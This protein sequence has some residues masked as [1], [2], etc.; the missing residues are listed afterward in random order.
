M[1]DTQNFASRY[2]YV[3]HDAV[4]DLS[5]HDALR[6]VLTPEELQDYE[7]LGAVPEDVHVEVTW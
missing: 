5:I 7:R 3:D 4:D 2:A 1:T 6:G